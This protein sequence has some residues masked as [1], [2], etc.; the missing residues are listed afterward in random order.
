MFADAYK[1]VKSVVVVDDIER[2]IDYNEIGYRYSNV[3]LQALLVLFKKRPPPVCTVL[4]GGLW[5]LLG[6]H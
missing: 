2:L 1:S 6:V 3:I 5:D 4:S